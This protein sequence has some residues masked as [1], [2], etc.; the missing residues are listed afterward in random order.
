MEKLH[1]NSMGSAVTLDGHR[2]VLLR[3]SGLT[4]VRHP[5][6]GIKKLPSFT[7]RLNMMSEATTVVWDN[8]HGL[9][10]LPADLAGAL[11]ARSWAKDVTNEAFDWWNAQFEEPAVAAIDKAPETGADAGKKE[12]VEPAKDNAPAPTPAPT[13]APVA[14]EEPKPE[15]VKDVPK[16]EAKKDE[17]KAEAPKEQPKVEAKEA[18]KAEVKDAEKPKPAAT[19]EELLKR[20][21][22]E[23]A[24]SKK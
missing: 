14:K 19:K 6:D 13:P 17:P 22:A 3:S 5:T 2:A 12:N 7:F 11:L 20:A 23:A 24:G 8:P 1:R 9:A 18:P 15:P 21:E 4:E 10:V 16:V